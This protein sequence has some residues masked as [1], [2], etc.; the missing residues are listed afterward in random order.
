MAKLIR[1]T[2]DFYF[3]GLI[4]YQAGNDYPET[5]E[6]ARHV[7]LGYAEFVK[8]K[9]ALVASEPEAPAVETPAAPDS[10]E[11]PAAE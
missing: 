6:T 8:G 9:S 4:K 1:Y 5:E 11:A 2:Q 10:P 3:S 7:K